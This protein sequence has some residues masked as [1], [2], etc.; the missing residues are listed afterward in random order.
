LTSLINEL[1]PF[2]AST[3]SEPKDGHLLEKLFVARSGVSLVS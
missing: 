1:N 2:K 3:W